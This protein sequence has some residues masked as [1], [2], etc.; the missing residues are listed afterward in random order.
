MKGAELRQARLNRGWTQEEAARKLG[1]A[2]SYVSMLERNQRTASNKLLSRLRRVYQ[3]PLTAEP[4]SKR[5]T[6][7]SSKKVAKALGAFGYPGYVYLRGN[8]QKNPAEVL[9]GALKQPDLESRLVR[10][11][12]WVV[13]QYP[14]MDWSTVLY[15]TKVANLQ[16]RL[17][18]VVALAR[19]LALRGKNTDHATKLRSVL[20]EL[21][22]SRLV[23]EDTLCHDSL[24]ETEKRWLRQGGR[25][26]RAR[27]WNLLTDMT[28][29]DVEAAY[30]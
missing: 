6:P 20:E 21:K 5:T 9:L 1:V 22:R 13:L 23:S 29:D 4:F 18:F 19:R 7:L 30:A 14:A 12:P 16:N 3:L 15:E 27:Y 8:V 2:Q 26:K 28:P 24:S 10:A 11:L 25:S 17:G